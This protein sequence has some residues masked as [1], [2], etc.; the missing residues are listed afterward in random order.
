[1]QWAV[2]DHF[3]AAGRPRMSARAARSPRSKPLITSVTG[4]NHG[5]EPGGL[6]RH[7]AA[8]TTS[9]RRIPAGRWIHQSR[10]PFE[11]GKMY[12]LRVVVDEE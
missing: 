4:R 10:L 7:G 6:S 5:A 3:A 2:P 12:L 11:D 8:R 9:G 1:M